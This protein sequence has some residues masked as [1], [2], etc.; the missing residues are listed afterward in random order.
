MTAARHVSNLWETIR[1]LTP[2][3]VSF[4]VLLALVAAPTAA[5]SAPAAKPAAPAPPAQAEI[6]KAV[7]WCAELLDRRPSPF[8]D[9]GDDDDDEDAPDGIME[10]EYLEGAARAC[11]ERV[12]YTYA[13]YPKRLA[14]AMRRASMSPTISDDGRL[15]FVGMGLVTGGSADAA[16]GRFYRVDDAGRLQTAGPRLDGFETV[17]PDGLH[18]LPFPSGTLYLATS[19]QRS[20]DT[21]VTAAADV[22]AIRQGKVVE[23]AALE[24]D[25]LLG[26]GGLDVER[27]RGEVLRRIPGEKGRVA[28]LRYR[29]VLYAGDRN[30]TGWSGDVE[31][32]DELSTCPEHE[33]V[34]AAPDPHVERSAPPQCKRAGRLAFDGERFRVLDVNG[35][36]VDD[37]SPGLRRLC[38]AG[39]RAR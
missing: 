19:A 2:V 38:R 16:E 1:D 8:A 13:R 34:E 24:L 18:A 26:E 27:H 21:C 39:G 17:I 20:C 10:I 9:Y 36:C 35:R 37:L 29:I 30:P 14:A 3:G 12:I 31:V 28:V 23:R 33:A 5:T 15:W 6:D 7:A 22:L 32:P 25:F 11:R 4:A